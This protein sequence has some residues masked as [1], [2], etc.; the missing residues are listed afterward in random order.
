[1][2]AAMASP[3]KT[4]LAC[5]LLAAALLPAAASWSRGPRTSPPVRARPRPRGHRVQR[6][7]HAGAEPADPARQRLLQGPAGQKG[8]ALYGVFLEAC[9]NSTESL[10]T[11]SSFKIID[12]QGNEFEP[13]ELPEDNDFAYHPTELGPDHASRR[14]GRSLSSGRRPDRCC[15]SSSRSPTPTTGRSSS[16]SRRRPRLRIPNRSS[17]SSWISSRWGIPAPLE[18][19]VHDQ[20][21]RRGGRRA[22]GARA[23]EMATPTAMRGRP[24]GA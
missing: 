12:N 14:P 3:A 1:M 17:S 18:R 8:E 5:A 10:P 21:R 11:A 20:L 24:T 6:L 23:H 13:T 16:R 4:V 19:G 7:H 15:S 2:P 22:A 9:N